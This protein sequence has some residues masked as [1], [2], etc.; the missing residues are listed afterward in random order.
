MHGCVW[1]AGSRYEDTWIDGCQDG[2]GRMEAGMGMDEWMDGWMDGDGWMDRWMDGCM[3]RWMDEWMYARMIE[4]QKYRNI[5]QY[6]NRDI[7]GDGHIDIE[8]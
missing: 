5:G 6:G 3:D 1:R 7:Y 4:R 8:R 2:D